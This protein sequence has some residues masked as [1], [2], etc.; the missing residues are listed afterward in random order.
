[1]IGGDKNC[2][3]L[4][5]LVGKC[6][7]GKSAVENK[8]GQKGFNICTSHTTRPMRPY[9]HTGVD[10]HFISDVEYERLKQEGKFLETTEYIINGNHW[11]YGLHVNSIKD[12][13]NVVVVNADGLMQILNN[14]P[15]DLDV[16]VIWLQA[17]L[18]VL[19]TRYLNREGDSLEVR[20]QLIDRLIRDSK[21]FDENF[22][23][24]LDDYMIN[25]LLTYWVSVDNS[26]DVDY[27]IDF[28]ADYIIDLLEEFYQPQV[29]K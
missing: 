18:S 16:F 19:I 20:N 9:E 24:K 26:D 29:Q 8:L 27:K 2:K 6:A 7:V 10:Y 4:I 3:K 28:I 21:D 12:G 5:V 13:L 22:D 25:G 23:L 17:P 15:A 11:K 14:K 1:M